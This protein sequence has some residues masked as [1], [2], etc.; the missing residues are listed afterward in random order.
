M[1]RL[2]DYIQEQELE[3]IPSKGS[4]VYTLYPNKIHNSIDKK[5]FESVTEQEYVDIV[6]ELGSNVVGRLS[7][8]ALTVFISDVKKLFNIWVSDRNKVPGFIPFRFSGEKN[9]K[10]AR[11]YE[12]YLNDF[13]YTLDHKVGGNPIYVKKVGSCTIKLMIGNGNGGGLN[14]Y[15]FE[16]DLCG[17][18]RKLISKN[19][20]NGNPGRWDASNISNDK[21]VQNALINIC[22]QSKLTVDI[23]NLLTRLL[24]A[25]YDYYIID[26]NTGEER[27]N[28]ETL[29]KFIYQPKWPKIRNTRGDGNNIPGLPHVLRTENNDD[30]LVGSGK[31]ISDIVIGEPEVEKDNIPDDNRIFISVKQNNAQLSGVTVSPSMDGVRWMDDC[32][33]GVD[34]NGN[35]PTDE[36]SKM[37]D[38]FYSGIGLDPFEVKWKMRYIRGNDRDKKD[39]LKQLGGDNQQNKY[40][41]DPKSSDFYNLSIQSQYDSKYMGKVLQNLIGG[42]YWYVSPKQ[43][44]WVDSKDRGWLFKID[45]PSDK[46]RS[47]YIT[48][49]GKGIHVRGNVRGIVVDL[50]LRTSGSQ[51][52]PSRLFPQI[53]DLEKLMKA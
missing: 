19:W 3:R 10:L 28:E 20:N 50:V 5:D 42:N 48:E 9:I 25:N 52:Y 26:D 30:F 35:P 39:A 29:K 36:N 38:N 18:V 11:P 21:Y 15:Q 41:I 51:D 40:T 43:C 23:K 45:Q 34:K 44:F 33:R 16:D 31:I 46:N 27:P 17:C 24:G 7:S 13:G 1:R 37:F 32:F 22:N 49:A 2:V 47:A 8:D 53:S 14:G 6:R 4:F 12:P